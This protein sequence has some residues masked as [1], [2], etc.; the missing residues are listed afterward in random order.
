MW[1][2]IASAVHRMQP[3]PTAELMRVE[4]GESEEEA[5]REEPV[6]ERIGGAVG[7]DVQDEG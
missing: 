5:Q 2:A 7:I 1:L 6:G 3:P 4:P